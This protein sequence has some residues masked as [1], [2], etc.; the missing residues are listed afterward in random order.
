MPLNPD[1]KAVIDRMTVP[2]A[3]ALNTLTPEQARARMPVVVPPPEVEA[4]A[5]SEDRRIPGPGGDI[6]AR[7]Y[8]PAGAGPFPALVFYHGGGW[9]IGSVDGSEMSSRGLANAAGCVV[10]SVDYR[11]APEHRFPAAAEDAFAAAQWTMANARALNV[12]PQRVGVSG[13]SA[14]G[15]LAAVVAQMARD[16]GGPALACQLLVVPVTDMNFDTASYSENKDGPQLTKDA[17]LWFWDLY[18]NDRSEALNPYAAPLRAA[19]LAGLPPA[20][21]LT[22]E[23]D[24][25]R[26][27]GHAYAAALQAA[28]VPVTYR[29][30]EGM[31]HG[32][33]GLFT[34]VPAIRQVL[35]ETGAHLRTLLA[36]KAVV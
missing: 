18:L 17:M 34:Q 24:P 25:L 11:L 2:G 10:V 27:E 21:V 22:A 15:N 32:F 20:V 33:F 29:C 12:D 7:I 3:P 13:V 14:G 36:E 35:N 1:L 6:P 23:F 19:S 30:L 9:V 5:H 8:T 28:G 26:D 31:T 16:R 4:V